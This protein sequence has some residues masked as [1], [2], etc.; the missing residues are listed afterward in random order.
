VAE[1]GRQYAVMLAD[2]S[3]VDLDGRALAAGLPLS[4]EAGR[5]YRLRVCPR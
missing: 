3:S 1:P 5:A 2:G 4:I